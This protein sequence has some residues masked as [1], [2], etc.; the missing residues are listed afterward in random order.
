MSSSVP[1][2]PSNFGTD[3]CFALN[4]DPS[5][6]PDL[7]NPF[8]IIGGEFQTNIEEKKERYIHVDIARSGTEKCHADE[9]N[10]CCS[11]DSSTSNLERS[12]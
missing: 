4:R 2:S 1:F 9:K 7:N 11:Q 8:R 5:A 10:M 12:L 3:D 6:F